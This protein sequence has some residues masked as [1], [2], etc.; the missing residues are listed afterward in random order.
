MCCIWAWRSYGLEPDQCLWNDLADTL[1]GSKSLSVW[2]RVGVDGH[3][4][5][6]T[7]VF[8]GVLLCSG[9][10]KIEL[11]NLLLPRMTR[12]KEA[13]PG[14]GDLSDLTKELM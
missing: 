9:R 2:G 11:H 8:F 4:E 14:T 12:V 3:L 10:L 1:D 5:K 13:D 7:V 6:S